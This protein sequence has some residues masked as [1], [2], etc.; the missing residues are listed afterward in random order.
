[1][2]DYQL[3][4]FD[5]DGY[6]TDQREFKKVRYYVCGNRALVYSY[7]KHIEL[8]SAILHEDVIKSY[9]ERSDS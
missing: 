4:A 3:I 5:M 6:I 1:M 2:R 7:I 9:R 8:Q